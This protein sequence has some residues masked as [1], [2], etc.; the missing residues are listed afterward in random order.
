MSGPN[1]KQAMKEFAA[2]P[3]PTSLPRLIYLTDVLDFDFEDIDG[4]DDDTGEAPESPGHGTATW[5]HDIYMVDTPNKDDSDNPEDKTPGQKPKRRRRRRP[6]S[7]NCEN[8][9]KSAR[10]GRYT[11]KP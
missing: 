8:G 11:I 10:K 6:K 3:P 7:S 4:M 9:N 5:S 1:G 2:H